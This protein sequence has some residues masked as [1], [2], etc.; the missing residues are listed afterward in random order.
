[1]PEPVSALLGR[2]DSPAD[3]FP[4]A[5]SFLDHRRGAKVVRQSAVGRQFSTGMAEACLLFNCAAASS[6]DRENPREIQHPSPGGSSGLDQLSR[7]AA[8]AAQLFLVLR[9]IRQ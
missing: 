6:G 5:S 4:L 9:V 7:L 1:M 2:E 8:D 3:S